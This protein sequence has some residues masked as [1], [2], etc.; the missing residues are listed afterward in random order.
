MA[1][2]GISIT[3]DNEYNGSNLLPIHSALAFIADITYTGTTPDII[4][5]EIRDASDV[6]LETYKAIPYNDLLATIRQFVFIA[7]EPIKSLMESFDDF[8][9]LN[10]TL[11]FVEDITKILKIRFVDPDNALIYDEIEVDFLHGAA[12]FGENPNKDAQF[13][14][15]SDVYYAAKDKFVYVYFYNDDEANDV[16]IDGAVLTEGNAL[17]YDDSIFTDYDDSVFTIDTII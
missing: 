15:D 16:A 9:Q 5:V 10:E 4:N 13:N 7:N 6:L 17:D 11:E 8:L 1:I 14:N 2:T 3:Q 12:Q